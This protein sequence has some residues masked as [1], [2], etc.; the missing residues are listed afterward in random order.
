MN[1]FRKAASVLAL[2]MIGA[3]CSEFLSGPGLTENP[4]DPTEATAVQQLIAV[5]ANMATRLE[6]QIAR[7]A[8][9]FTQQLIGSNNQQLMWCTGYGITESDI[10]GA[11]SGFY[12]GAGLKGI[13]NV[14]QLARASADSLMVGMALVWEGLSMGTAAAVWGDLPYS[15]ALTAGIETPELDSQ[16]DLYTA[17]Q[18]RLDEGIAALTAARNAI[19]A[20]PADTASNCVPNGLGTQADLIYCA[21]AVR[22]LV[23]IGRWIRAAYTVKARFYLHLVE[24]NGVSAYTTALAAAN[25]GINEAPTSPTQAIH[26]QAAGDFRTF[27]G[28]VQDVDA[29]IWGEFLLSRQDIVAGNAMIQILKARN[30]TVRMAAYFDAN[31]QL[32]YVGA[33]Q[34]NVTVTPVGCAAPCAASVLD[35]ATRRAFTFRQPLVTWAE[36][37][38]ILAEAKFRTGDSAGAAV[39]VNAVRTAVGLPALAAPTFVDVM[40]EKYI[41]QYQNIDVWADYKRTCIPTLTPNGGATEVLGRLPYGSAERTANNN[42]PLPSNYPTGTTG[43]SPVRNWND[44]DSC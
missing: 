6:G 33:D 19:L 43:V 11:M 34:D 35:A 21:T 2:T 26:G 32:Q 8:S 23:E 27:H 29:N 28:S 38:L 37:Q 25:L 17:V 40:T 44:P 10:S 5:Q 39:N 31:A 36:N 7:C 22:R 15:E 18:A 12:T 16:Q 1:T 4:N 3:G 14:Q 13:R 9:I 24:R 20:V 41:A 30:D 42:V